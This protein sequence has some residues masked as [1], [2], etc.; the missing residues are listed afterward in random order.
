MIHTPLFT[1]LVHFISVC[2]TL[3]Q[4]FQTLR[5]KVSHKLKMLSVICQTKLIWIYLASGWY[6]FALNKNQCETNCLPSLEKVKQMWKKRRHTSHRDIWNW[7][8]VQREIQSLSWTTY[9]QSHSQVLAPPSTARIILWQD[10]WPAGRILFLS[11]SK[12]CIW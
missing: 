8:G 10:C 6:Y 5:K 9:L 11:D 7:N 3:W 1:P 4:G 2:E 12:Y